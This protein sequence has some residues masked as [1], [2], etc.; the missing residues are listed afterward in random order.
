MNIL[1]RIFCLVGNYLPPKLNCLFYKLSGVKFN[2]SKVWIGNKCYLDTNYPENIEIENGVCIS[3]GVSIIC[4]FDPSKSIKNHPIKKYKKKVIFEEGVFV[5]TNSTIMPG[6]I[7]RR[8]TFIKAGSV[9]TKSTNENT[10]V[11]GNPQKEKGYLS[12]KF[13]S[14][15]NYI[16]R[17][18][19]F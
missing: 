2:P 9:I 10:I 7:I 16:N 4:H 6:V 13:I 15:V 5:G 12:E 3:S 19:H 1:R 18:Y 8:N 17:K 11:Y 14:R